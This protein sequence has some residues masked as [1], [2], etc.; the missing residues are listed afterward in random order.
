MAEGRFAKRIPLVLGTIHAFVDLLCVT[1][2]LQAL[3]TRDMDAAGT[4]AIVV[5]YDLIAFAVQLPLGLLVD[6]LNAARASSIAGIVLS[7]MAV[8]SATGRAD[9]TMGLAGIGN[10][11]F[12]VGAGGMVLANARGRAA[13]A[14]LFVAP[15]SLGLGLGLWL[16]PRAHIPAWPLLILAA[17]SVAGAV[18]ARAPLGLQR[19]VLPAVEQERGLPARLWPA[20]LVLLLLSATVRGLIESVGCQW[21]PK[22]AFLMVALPLVGFTARLVG[23]YASDRL[24]WVETSV[25]ALLLSAPLIAFNHGS[26]VPALIGLLLFQM[27]MPVTL[28]AVWRVMPRRPATAFGFPCVGLVVGTILSGEVP[29]RRMLD[30]P[31]LLGLIAASATALLL[32]LELIGVRRK[33]R[34]VP[35]I[36]L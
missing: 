15:G 34:S 27:T 4:Y 36:A 18:L 9:T 20:A 32:A 6:K 19:A 14:G 33:Q 3:R 22:A 30:A 17:V 10:A 23:G 1:A 25:G 29:I 28:M 7:A 8:L 2:V 12:H 13:P 21:C 16:G 26:V 11:L 35:E 5:G 31:F 24:G